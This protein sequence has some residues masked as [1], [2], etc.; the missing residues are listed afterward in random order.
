MDRNRQW[1]WHFVTASRGNHKQTFTKTA[2]I[3]WICIPIDIWQIHIGSFCQQF[4]TDV[5][6]L[7][8]Y[9]LTEGWR[10]GNAETHTETTTVQTIHE[11]C[12][13]SVFT[14]Q[15]IHEL[16]PYNVFTVQTQSKPFMSYVHTMSLQSKPFMSY[17]RTTP[18]YIHMLQF[19]SVQ[20]T[21]RC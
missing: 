18:L 12:P 11:L 17:V 3:S 5:H 1:T 14:V 4:L 8:L 9:S 20:F 2:I 19:S 15:T 21:S 16:C 13:Y 7:S 10:L 6:A